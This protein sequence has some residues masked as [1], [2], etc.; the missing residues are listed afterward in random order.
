MA[1]LTGHITSQIGDY[2][3]LR[4]KNYRYQMRHGG[5]DPG[6]EA[7][8][9]LASLHSDLMNRRNT[10]YNTGA[11]E[12]LQRRVEAIWGS[13]GDTYSENGGAEVAS[14]ALANYVFSQAQARVNR[15]TQDPNLISIGKNSLHV[16]RRSSINISNNIINNIDFRDTVLNFQDH[17]NQS[18]Y[19]VKQIRTQAEAI[20]GLI[21]GKGYEAL[22]G[23]NGG[24]LDLVLRQI[25]EAAKNTLNQARNFRSTESTSTSQDLSKILD[26]S[27]NENA[28]ISKNSLATV[29]GTGTNYDGLNWMDALNAIRRDIL[30]GTLG[31]ETEVYSEGVVSAFLNGLEEMLNNNMAAAYQA[32]RLGIDNAGARGEG[33][34]T[35]DIQNIADLDWKNPGQNWVAGGQQTKNVV[36]FSA[37]FHGDEFN[38]SQKV[39]RLHSEHPTIGFRSGKNILVLV[40]EYGCFMNH[41]LNICVSR[42]GDNIQDEP[43]ES[44]LASSMH[45]TFLKIIIIRSVLGGLLK[46][47]SGGTLGRNAS[48][49]F[50]LI[51]DDS[52]SPPTPTLWYIHDILMRVE[53]SAEMENFVRINN[54]KEWKNKK[55]GTVLNSSDA[56][57]RIRN[58]ITSLKVAQY[59]VSLP[60]SAFR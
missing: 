33:R 17:I 42:E 52:T 53:Y 5:G 10:L 30:I 18:Y 13:S 15:V 50:V 47:Y 7:N 37:V 6:D 9:V 29:S 3:F 51:V 14:G 21:N 34:F 25:E 2:V 38:I 36:D 26:I 4:Y 28:R 59:E 12:G 40:Q 1:D 24:Q 48:V 31:R 19:T 54:L 32:V 57:I 22:I 60:K 46:T 56:A 49:D 23:G 43:V 41:Y 27:G 35:V 58:L 20:I 39:T 11:R 8:R 55:V 44:S 16:N 45:R